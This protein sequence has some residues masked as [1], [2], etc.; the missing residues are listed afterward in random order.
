M[1]TDAALSELIDNAVSRHRYA[2]DT[3]F[4]REKTYFPKLALVQIKTHETTA[5]IDPLTVDTSAFSRLFDSESLCVVHAAQQD[6]EVLQHAV[7]AIPKR[8][9][10]TQLSSGFIGLSTP[11]LASLVQNELKISLP[12]GDRLTDWLRRP[13][14]ADQMKYAASDVEYLFILHDKINQKLEQLGRVSWAQEACEELRS[15]PTSPSDPRDAWLKIKEVRT[16]KPGSRGTAQALAQW[17]ELKAITSD[18]PPRRVLSDIAL[19]GIAHAMPET[20][21]DLSLIRGVESRQLGPTIS[22]EIIAMV[23]KGRSVDARFPQSDADDIDKEFRPAMSLIAAWIGELARIHDI[24]A[25]LLGTRQDIIDLLRPNKTSRLSTGW[26]AEMVG[27]DIERILS[28]EAGLSFDGHGRLRL[29]PTT[30]Q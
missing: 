15:R 9:F 25:T 14:S 29:L 20:V 22:S 19:I 10:D 11:S 8:I 6:M 27:R 17:R 2:L 26:R 30:L 1:D 23:Q 12:K 16:L 5:I 18:I 13:L 28:G 7:G 21:E 4:H 24:D 3:E